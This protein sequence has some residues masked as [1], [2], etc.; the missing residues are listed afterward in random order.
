[1]SANGLHV[2]DRTLDKTNL[3]LKELMELLGTDDRHRAYSILRVTLH[4][5]RDRLT[6][7]EGAQL[8]AQLPLLIRGVYYEGWNP[9]KNAVR[10][11]SKDHFLAR[12]QGE[13][14]NGSEIDPEQA[15]R[16]VFLLL[17]RHVTHGEINDVEH[18]LP[19][20]IRQLWPE[21]H[22]RIV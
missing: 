21:P 17:D 7:E 3:W 6:I 14:A 16:S 20:H 1:M 2:F 19:A 12:I 10:D 15:A 18:I 13:L 8:A 11:R 9:A 4:A 5:L 22:R